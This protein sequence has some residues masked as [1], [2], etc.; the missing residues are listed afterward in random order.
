MNENKSTRKFHIGIDVSKETLVAALPGGLV[1]EFANDKPGLAALA[2]EIKK[3][4]ESTLV[5]CE[6]TGGCER[7][8]R[9]ACHAAAIP[10]AV[11]N[12][13]RVRDFAK[14]RGILAKT[15]AIDARMIASYAAENHPRPFEPPPSWSQRLRELNGRRDTL[16]ADRVRETNRLAAESDKWVVKSIQRHIRFLEKE[17]RLLLKEIAVLRAANPE[18]KEK[19]DRLEAVK[20]IGEGS[21]AVLLGCIPELGKIKDNEA[22]A[23]AGLAPYNN[24]SGKFRGQR[25]IKGGR[26]QVRRVLYMAALAAARS[27]HILKAFYERLIAKG[28]HHK[29][30]LTAVMRKLVCL[31][32]RILCDP[33]FTPANA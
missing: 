1:R 8:L 2:A 5:C 17:L 16:S 29:T 33:A 7:A 4:G 14:G 23:L 21:A 24:D 9:D 31:A 6:A 12:A 15:D 20:G 27:N 18:F 25:H 32:N 22:A 19:A 10:V 28:K 30:A 3:H 26:P 13:K 11:V